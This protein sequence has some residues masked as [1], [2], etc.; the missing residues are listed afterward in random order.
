MMSGDKN[1]IYTSK[2][3]EAYFSG[4]L[5]PS[6]MHAMEKDALDD[7]FLAEAMEGYEAMRGRSW[8]PQLVELHRHFEEE[9]SPAKV[10][11]LNR[12]TSRWWKVAAAILVIGCGATVTYLLTNKQ[13]GGSGKGEIAKVEPVVVPAVT[14]K[15]D[16]STSIA[17]VNTPVV[18]DKVVPTVAPFAQ[19]TKLPTNIATVTTEKKF[20][21]EP[22]NK[23]DIVAVPKQA[24]VDTKD[25]ITASNA[26]LDKDKNA[27]LAQSASKIAPPSSKTPANISNNAVA[28]NAGNEGVSARA[29]DETKRKAPWKRS[30]SRTNQK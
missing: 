10:I 17:K 24:P 22:V 2:D 23:A 11:P 4:Q 5:S 1:I 3:I 12:S 14:P 9:R 8:K 28:S 15:Q 21:T 27:D 18:K 6:R 16:T 20:T 25:K 7:P 26:T 30:L 13:P 29:A 19:N